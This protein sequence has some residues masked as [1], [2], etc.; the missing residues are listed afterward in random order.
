M[1][2]G[3]DFAAAVKLTGSRFVVMQGQIARLHRALSQ[4]MLDLH[5][6]QHGYTETY[7]PYRLTMRPCMAPA[8]C[9]NSAK[10]C[11]IPVRW[12]KKRTA[13]TMR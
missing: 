9:Q 2:K 12:K 7:V 3:T 4:F 8:S 10:I 11:F 13:A 5:T 1:A 6:Q